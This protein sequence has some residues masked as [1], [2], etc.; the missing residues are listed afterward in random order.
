MAAELSLRMQ[1]IAEIFDSSK[2][3]ASS[4]LVYLSG[5][6]SEELKFLGGIWV[7][8]DAAR[9]HQVI[10]QLVHLSEVDFRLDFS[11]VFVLC[12]SDPD[13]TIRIQA[14]TGL[15]GE[16]N[17]LLITPLLRA[18][19]EDSSAEVRTAATIA[20]GKF[21]FLGELGKIP[22]HYKNKIYTALLEVLENKVEAA[23]MRRRALEAVSPFD[24]PRVK[25]LIEQAYHTDDVKLRASAIYAMGRNCDSAW[26]TTLMTELNSNEVE[27]RYE[28]ASACGELGA[29]EAVP[30]LL[31][32]IKDEDCQVQEAAI[33]AL[34]QIGGEQA[35][36][37]LNKLAKNPQ[38]RIREAAK[39]ALE[40]IHFC[41]DPLFFQPQPGHHC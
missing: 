32:L 9:R 30:Q 38:P 6:S 15:D 14:V 41:E 23:G 18:L 33:E 4:K 25:E 24:L 28:A 1:R 16:E 3:V 13:E 29:E 22:T 27:I 31:N 26:L 17:Y 2:P 11:G 7:N 19:K 39:S 10:S 34:G 40:E 21:A 35:K 12:L 37:A 5:L 20:L 36:Q 8:A